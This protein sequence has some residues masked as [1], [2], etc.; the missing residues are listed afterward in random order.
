MLQLLQN[1]KK[2]LSVSQNWYVLFLKSQ[3]WAIFVLQNMPIQIFLWRNK[4]TCLIYV[5]MSFMKS[6]TVQ[7]TLS[8]LFCYF[9]V[10]CLRYLAWYLFCFFWPLAACEKR[11]FNN[12][13]G[14]W[15]PSI[16]NSVSD[17]IKRSGKI[18]LT[19]NVALPEQYI[20][21]TI[22]ATSFENGNGKN[23]A[24]VWPELG[25]LNSILV[26]LEWKKIIILRTVSDI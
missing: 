12:F 2:W 1:S 19:I 23:T 22:V 5:T 15:N 9:Y 21:T 11:L 18:S 6:I 24:C 14:P 8:F 26:I 20:Q 10:C 25:F 17:A 7:V 4:K 13:L 3:F 16:D